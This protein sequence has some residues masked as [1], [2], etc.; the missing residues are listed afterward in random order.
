MNTN[1]TFIERYAL[2][3][4][5]ILTPLLGIAIPL[6]LPLPPVVVVFMAAFVPALMAILLTAMTDGRKGVAALL[7]KVFQWRIGFKWYAI[8]LGLPLGI[9]LAIGVLALLLG[10]IPAIQIRPWS[11]PQFIVGV[12]ILIWAVLEEVGW[13]GYALPKVLATR[14]ALFSALLIG[15]A[16]GVFH[17]GLG[18]MESRP[19]IPTFLVPFGFSVV[20]TWLFIQTRGN[21]VMATLCHF[22]FN[23]FVIFEEGMTL[24]Q[25]LWLEAIVILVFA[26]IL[27]ILFGVDLQHSPMKRPAVVDV[28]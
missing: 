5:L 24:A 8:A 2:P 19:L 25:I 18:A 15:I 20:L 28:G 6:F 1:P 9:H 13:R 4:F 17:L 27:V 22:G 26:F 10:W 23:Y 7:Q 3:L 21:L 14:S 12:L 16:W 11:L